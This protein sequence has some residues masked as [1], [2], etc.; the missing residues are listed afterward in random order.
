MAKRILV[1]D[2]NPMI[3]K[4]LCRLFEIEEDYD[5]CAEAKM[6]RKRLNW[7]CIIVLI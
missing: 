6:D 5:I 4:M 7:R 2:D 1:A 3:R